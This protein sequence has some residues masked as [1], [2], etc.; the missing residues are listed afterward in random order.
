MATEAPILN[1]AGDPAQ[2]EIEPHQGFPT[3]DL[4]DEYS[5]TEIESLCMNC[6]ED[7]GPTLSCPSLPYPF[8]VHP[9]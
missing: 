8:R 9:Y 2:P 6:H 7:V 1:G 4:D 3:T 5:V